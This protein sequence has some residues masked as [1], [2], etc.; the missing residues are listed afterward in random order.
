MSFPLKERKKKR[1]ENN[2][3][4]NGEPRGQGWLIV[5]GHNLVINF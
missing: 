2:A 5:D 3:G 4:N 1:A